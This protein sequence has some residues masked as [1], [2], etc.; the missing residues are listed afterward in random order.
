MQRR[1]FLKLASLALA[2][3]ASWF[4]T[5]VAT[6]TDAGE[7]MHYQQDPP[8]DWHYADKVT[9]VIPVS[10]GTALID[11]TLFAPGIKVAHGF[12]YLLDTTGRG[13]WNIETRPDG[14]VSF[15]P[16]VGWEWLFRNYPSANEAALMTAVRCGTGGKF[17]IRV[18]RQLATNMQ[19]SF[20]PVWWFS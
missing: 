8:V 19:W 6:K 12:L 10:G 17:E 15:P 2:P 14:L 13:P 11:L 5:P 3:L 7:T 20:A 18:T 16:D 1:S 4:K 9:G